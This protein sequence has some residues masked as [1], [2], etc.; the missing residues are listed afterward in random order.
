MEELVS[1]ETHEIVGYIIAGI[2][3][4]FLFISAIS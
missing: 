3:I 2:L 1:Q 4:V